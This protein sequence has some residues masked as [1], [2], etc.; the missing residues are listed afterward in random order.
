MAMGMGVV[1]LCLA[2]VCSCAAGAVDLSKAV[3]VPS[4][5]RSGIPG[6]A[7]D[8]LVDRVECNSRIRLACASRPP[9]LGSW[10]ELRIAGRGPVD[11]YAIEADDR[12]VVVTGNDGRGLL[13]GVGR[14]LREL[15]TDRDRVECPSP[16]SLVT[17]PVDPIRGHQLGYRPK[18][19]SYDGWT[20]SMWLRYIQDL[21]IFGANA[22]ELIPPVS[23]DAPDSP[24]FPT[25]QMEMMVA[26]SRMLKDYGMGVWVWYPAMEKDYADPVTAQRELR[27]W[28]EVLGRLPKLDNVFVPG[29]D[30]GHT[31]PSVLFAFLDKL[32]PMVHR[33]HPGCGFW[34]AP[35][36]FDS[37]WFDEFVSLARNRHP[38]W[39]T[40]VVHGPQVRV[41]ARELQALVGSRYRLRHYP[42]ITHTRQSQ[43]AVP[44]W[45]LAWALTEG[46]EPINPRPRDMKAIMN[47]PDNRVGQGSIC[48]SEGCND[49]VNKAVWSGLAW[50]HNADPGELLRQY[51]R[52]YMGG[53]MADQFADCLM[54]LETNWHGAAA[55]NPGIAG[56][57]AGLEAIERST[58]PRAMLNWRFQQAMYRGVY[59]AYVQSRSAAAQANERDALM[60]LTSAH[61]FGPTA[62]AQVAREILAKPDTN[63]RARALR[64]RLFVLAEALYQSIRMQLDTARYLAIGTER[65][66]NLDSVDA[67]LNDAAWILERIA[68]ILAQGS[69]QEQIARL[70]ALANGGRPAPGSFHDAP[71][72][73][74]QRSH[75][76]TPVDFAADPGVYRTARTGFG[77]NSLRLSWHRYLETTYEQ[78]LV[79]R[80][81]GL[82]P[83]ASYTL[84]VVYGPDSQP[85]ALRC[86]SGQLVVH[87][88][89]TKPLPQAPVEFEIP[90]EAY[91]TG[92]LSL[93]WSGKPGYGGN[94]RGC[95]LC[96]VWILKR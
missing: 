40:G 46:R 41:P 60:A 4:A 87:D 3:V 36:G 35:Q 76:V 43:Y 78:P 12:S 84:R 68:D 65:G 10:I 83:S 24:H 53:P 61:K 95:Q 59:D 47:A 17:A 25:P 92:A 42:D 67:P 38:S 71:G 79:M 77:G 31:R 39:L 88:W 55:T 93:E 16:W 20:K 74:A 66:A 90:R 19:N 45:D 64:S 63:D 33:K 37:A 54:G 27:Q 91:G 49:D 82:N 7:L 75:V 2:L 21:A 6:R 56:T 13:Y 5:G 51:S 30:P 94:G 70:E 62:V 44:D 52:A 26:M 50:D 11:G 9:S 14:L 15:R 96:E 1:I 8:L 22:V 32:A 81:E 48:Y 28:T 80:W 58:G 85:R 86:M 89:L 69:D 34:I 29:G 18:T 23:D 57:L 73:P 72:D